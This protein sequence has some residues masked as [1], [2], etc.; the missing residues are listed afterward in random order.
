MSASTAPAGPVLLA[1]DSVAEAELIGSLLRDDFPD[2]Q[3]CID[4][5]RPSAQL[6]SGQPD[7]LL[8]AFRDIEKAERF[9]LSLYRA[10]ALSAAQA[11]RTVVLCAREDCTR[12]YEM[13]RRGIF[14]D[15]VL[16]W[17]VTNDPK[18]LFMSLHR[19]FSE[20]QRAGSGAQL[21]A[22]FVEQARRVAGLE[23]TL[24][25][26]LQRGQ[27][28]IV[29]ATQALAGAQ[30]PL[31]AGLLQ[32]LA[33]WAMSLMPSLASHL[34]GARA[35]GEL[36]ARV[37]PLALVVDD[38][39]FQRRLVGHVLEAEGY[40]TAYAASG[41]EALRALSRALPDII[42]LDMD[43]PDIDGAE[44][45]RRCKSQP[46]LARVPVI[47]L[48]GNG[49]ADA[50]VGSRRLGAADFIVK[51]FDRSTLIGKISRALGTGACEAP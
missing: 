22:A 38:D 40:R 26:A 18:R 46:A 2:I 41:H 21:L 48:T 10:G 51:P 25:G 32:P 17:P 4:D 16:F 49:A 19:A 8:L 20:L 27:E 1:S 37:R 29:C 24:A 13:C 11:H 3:R 39:E 31:A 43:L 9:Y 45:L 23:T 33:S 34:E 35:L 15:Y 6:P 28:H 47:M 44:V 12:A 7:V 14:D 42:L 50:V 36:A 5:G 30:P